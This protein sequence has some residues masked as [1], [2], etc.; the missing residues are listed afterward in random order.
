MA[1]RIVGLVASVMLLAACGGDD[2][3]S[4]PEARPEPLVVYANYEDTEYL[5]E[6]F[7][8]FTEQSGIYVTVRHQDA[9][10][11]I[12]NMIDGR[13]QR[14]ADV[15]IAPRVADAWLVAENSGLRP[16]DRAV[17][18]ELVPAPLRD[19]DGYWAA[20]SYR[21][22]AI[23]VDSSRSGDINDA[24][25]WDKPWAALAGEDYKGKLCLSSSGLSI[26]RTLIANLHRQHGRREAEI[27]VRTW[28]RSL[29][30]PVF[31]TE[32]ELIEATGSGVCTIAI[33]SS[34]AVAEAQRSETMANIQAGFPAPTFADAEA[35]GVGRHAR[36][37]E[38]AMRLVAWMLAE[39]QQR[40][41]TEA[42]DALPPVDGG[43]VGDA[44]VAGWFDEQARALAERASY[45]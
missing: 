30:L 12:A 32:Q 9:S 41:H 11:N 28:I 24:I 23:I 10:A 20:F 26:N 33:A 1:C 5:P 18:E 45:R 38:L 8:P 19:V 39:E 44:G 42:I 22:P 25:D 21:L 13:N 40:R 17:V 15:F 14:P 31:E 3:A 7:K 6:F 4:S 27:L 36:Q 29:A 43:E 37:P 35:V 2:V 34:Q 16:L